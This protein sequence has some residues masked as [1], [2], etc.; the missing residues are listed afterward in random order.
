MSPGVDAVPSEE[1]ARRF[2]GKSFRRVQRFIGEL[3]DGSPVWFRQGTPKPHGFQ[4]TIRTGEPFGKDVASGRGYL[5]INTSRCWLIPNSVLRDWLG[6][7]LSQQTVDVYLDA[8]KQT[9]ST[10]GLQT[11]SVEGYAAGAE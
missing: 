6:G 2:P 1:A 3:T 5:C 7:K 11:I 9:L 10:G 8:G 4:V